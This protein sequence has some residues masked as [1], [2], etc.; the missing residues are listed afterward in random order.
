MT[1]ADS[2][3]LHAADTWL[4]I[5]DALPFG[6]QVVD[7]RGQV[8]YANTELRALLGDTGLGCKCHQVYKDPKET[9]AHFPAN[10]ADAAGASVIFDVEGPQGRTTFRVTHRPLQASGQE[11]ALEVFQDITEQ[12]Q[13]I[14]ELRNSEQRFRELVDLL[15]ETI[16]EADL[17][18]RVT[19][20]NQIAY[21]RFGYTPE[22]FEKGINLLE[23][24][25]ESAV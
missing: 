17:T 23:G 11:L 3:R 6:V 8:L 15:P 10:S 24:R 5:L 1:E 18:G 25:P 13:A 7:A 22:Q 14:V 9:C 12:Q 20:G 19:F 21:E 16:F 2:P 4:A